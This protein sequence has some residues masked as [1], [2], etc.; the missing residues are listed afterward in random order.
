MHGTNVILK[1]CLLL[2]LFYIACAVHATEPIVWKI[3][4]NKPS[5]SY[6]FLIEQQMMQQ[7]ELESSAEL[8][9]DLKGENGFVNPR[10]AYNALRTGNIDAMLMTPS[11]WGSADPVFAIMGDLVAA[12]NSP[13]QYLKW[14]DKSNGIKHLQNAYERVGL[15]LIGYCVGTAESLISRTPI[16]DADSLDGIIMRTPP[17]MISDFF[18]LLGAKVKN[19][20]GGK[21]LQAL[22]Q[23]R[24]Q[25][26]D[27]S[28][29]A[30]NQ[31]MGA[32]R[33]AKYSNYPGFHSMPLYDF[34]VRKQ[35]WNQLTNKQKDIVLSAVKQWQ[36]K[37]YAI[38]QT[39]MATAVM[40]VLS[41]GVTLHTWHHLEL[42]KARQS[43]KIVWDKYAT[44]SDQAK[45]LIAELKRWLIIEGNIDESN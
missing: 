29:L 4:T 22:E 45:Q 41:Q 7:I 18:R 39:H 42:K 14:L 8:T 1:Y 38:T 26:A 37:A 17:G 12:W 9:F 2:L 27:F 40:K 5:S 19:I 34:V 44:K 35:S 13:Q 36:S 23:K 6:L 25:A 3:Q 43:A 20:S 24:I 21:V 11:Y 32:Y 31:Q 28:D 15:L 30:I 16:A 33:I 10:S